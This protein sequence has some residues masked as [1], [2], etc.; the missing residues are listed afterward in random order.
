MPRVTTAIPGPCTSSPWTA[1]SSSV[2]W[3]SSNSSN[4]GR[5]ATTESATRSGSVEGTGS[6]SKVTTRRSSGTSTCFGVSPPRSTLSE[7]AMTS[8]PSPCR[9]ACTLPAGR[10]MA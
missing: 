4:G 6:A 1:S 10:W 2:A 7:A 3:S 9:Y 8:T 5:K